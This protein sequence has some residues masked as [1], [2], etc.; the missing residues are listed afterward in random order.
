MGLAPD[1]EQ[2]FLRQIFGLL[3][4]HALSHDEGLHL[5]GETREQERIGRTVLLSG[6]AG[7][8]HFRRIGAIFRVRRYH[9]D[10]RA[11]CEGAV[12]VHFVRFRDSHQKRVAFVYSQL[13]RPVAGSG[14]HR[15]RNSFLSWERSI[16][17]R[18]DGMGVNRP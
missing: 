16:V 13:L 18:V 6:Y 12:K 10:R 3:S 7:D 2:G 8:K 9:A 15:E 5:G 4:R 1:I 11:D 14:S 17:I